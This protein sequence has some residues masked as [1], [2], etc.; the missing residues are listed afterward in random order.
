MNLH[1]RIGLAGAALLLSVA[2][3]A[4]QNCPIDGSSSYFTGNTK[5]D[6]LTAKLLYEHKCARGH[7]FWS[8]SS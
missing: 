1:T 7:T 5:V 3:Y 8:T 2:A 4:S 6:S